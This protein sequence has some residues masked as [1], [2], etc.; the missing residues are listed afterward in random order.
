MADDRALAL[1]AHF[2]GHRRPGFGVMNWNLSRSAGMTGR[3]RR[4]PKSLEDNPM[5][6]TIKMEALKQGKWRRSASTC[7]RFGLAATTTERHCVPLW[8]RFLD[9]SVIFLTAPAWVPLMAGISAAIKILSPGP[10]LFRQE[11]VG[12]GGRCFECLKFRTMHTGAATSVH[13]K[14]VTDLIRSNRP[15][16]KLDG[17]DPRLIPLAWILRSSGLD[18]LPQLFNVLRGEMSLV[19]PRPCT[20]QEYKSYSPSQRAR[21]ETLPG[22]TGLWQVSGKNRTTFNEMIE[23]DIRYLKTSCLWLDVGIMLRTPVVLLADIVETIFHR[24]IKELSSGAKPSVPAPVSAA[25]SAQ[26]LA[27]DFV[28]AAPGTDPQLSGTAVGAI[29]TVVELGRAA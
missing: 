7:S 6:L 1:A 19:G 13:E 29:N 8:K 3:T 10:V 9:V 28:S 17:D 12:L 16:R 18:E 26:L 24:Q 21:S 20:T 22:L 27:R 4:C 14:H 11:R 2:K 15:M 23:L 25:S 5:N